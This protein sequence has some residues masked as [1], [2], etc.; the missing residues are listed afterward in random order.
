MGRSG[1]RGRSRRTT[2]ARSEVVAE[3]CQPR[4][5]TRLPTESAQV[6]LHPVLA[7]EFARPDDVKTAR[8]IQLAGPRVGGRY[9]EPE[10]FQIAPLSRSGN[11]IPK[12]APPDAMPP[13]LGYHVH[14]PQH[15]GAV[16]V[17]V[18]ANDPHQS[19]VERAHDEAALPNPLG[20]E[21]RGDA[22]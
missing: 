14:A 2:R 16:S 22:L 5:H 8:Q 18:E 19:G 11:G 15:R 1:T 20:L 4:N 12:K 17:L 13:A 3:P 21:P 10:S 6:Q 7:V 9:V